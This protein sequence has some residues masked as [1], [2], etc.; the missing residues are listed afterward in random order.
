[1]SQ[2]GIQRN[3][4]NFLPIY[5]PQTVILY[6]PA[7]LT[8]WRISDGVRFDF[9]DNTTIGPGGYLVIAADQEC[10]TAAHGNIPIVGNWRGGLRDGGELIRIEDENGNLV[11]EVD[12]LPEGDWPNLADG[13][14]SSMELRHPSMNNNISSAWDDSDE[15]N[16]SAMQKFTY[17]GNFDRSYWL[18]LRSGQELHTHL[19]GDSHVIL[20]NISVTLNDSGSNL[21]RN[22]AVMS[23]SSASSQAIFG[24]R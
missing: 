17:T 8:G 10:L 22:P 6:A 20:E 3:S 21:L 9:P 7:N 12:Y 14:G 16:K 5:I 2:N 11:D 13:D 4:S 18:P 19:V 1:M 23:Q 24:H 15:S